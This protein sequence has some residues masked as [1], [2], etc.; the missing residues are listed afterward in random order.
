MLQV[1]ECLATTLV[2]LEVLG[3][4]AALMKLRRRYPRLHLNMAS[5]CGDVRIAYE[6]VGRFDLAVTASRRIWCKAGLGLSMQ[7]HAIIDPCQKGSMM[8]HLEA[9]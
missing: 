2:K 4:V 6:I 3:A 5:L 9:A 7:V 1:H 8:L